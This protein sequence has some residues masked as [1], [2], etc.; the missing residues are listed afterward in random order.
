MFIPY[1]RLPWWLSS[2]ESAYNAGD[3]GSIPGSGRSPGR[4]DGNPLQYSCLWNP[5]DRG[6]WWA[7]VHGIS[8]L[9]TTSQLNNKQ[10]THL[11]I[12]WVRKYLYQNVETNPCHKRHH[13]HNTADQK[14]TPD[15]QIVSEENMIWTAHLVL[16]LLRHHPKDRPSYCL[17]LKADGSCIQESHRICQKR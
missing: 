13:R 3:T 9:D 11:H 10:Q 14:W 4:G 16:Q 15:L 1:L 6:A 2:K 8:E 17:G 7:T 12:E 5:M